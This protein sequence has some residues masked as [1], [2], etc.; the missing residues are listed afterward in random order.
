MEPFLTP[1]AAYHEL[2]AVIRSSADAEE[3]LR[4]KVVFGSVLVFLVLFGDLLWGFCVI[5]IFAT[6]R[7]E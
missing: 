5:V 6:S 3:F 1:I 4:V 2:S 7:I